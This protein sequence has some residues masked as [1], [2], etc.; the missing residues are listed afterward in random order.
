MDSVTEYTVTKAVVAVKETSM[1]F[2][3]QI[4]SEYYKTF[5]TLNI[6]IYEALQT[7]HTESFH[8]C[9][10]VK[11]SPVGCEAMALNRTVMVCDAVRIC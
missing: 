1:S 11:D 7:S 8:V 5:P 6:G 2:L 9:V 3:Y 4:H 10:D